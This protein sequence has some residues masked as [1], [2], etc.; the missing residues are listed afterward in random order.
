MLRLSHLFDLHH[1][2]FS[3]RI[4]LREIRDIEAVAPTFSSTPTVSREISK[5]PR[6][7]QLSDSPKRRRK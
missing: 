6:E 2:E 5:R 3:P 1:R 4:Q 7:I